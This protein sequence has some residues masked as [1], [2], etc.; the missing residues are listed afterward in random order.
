MLL[1]QMTYC[2]SLITNIIPLTLKLTKA[3]RFRIFA[4]LQK[5]I[6]WSCGRV[7]RQRSAKPCT[8]VQIRSGPQPEPPIHPRLAVSSFLHSFQVPPTV[9]SAPF[10]SL[11]LINVSVM[12]QFLRMFQFY[13]FLSTKND[14]H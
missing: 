14:L 12:F 7:V 10:R 3:L 5:Q 8:A 9:V 2:L 1:K 13:S 6:I 4:S 11:P